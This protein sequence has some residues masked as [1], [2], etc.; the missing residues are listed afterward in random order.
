MLLRTIQHSHYL[1]LSAFTKRQYIINFVISKGKIF[2]FIAVVCSLHLAV[3]QVSFPN[4]IMAIYCETPPRIDGD[5]TDSI[6]IVAPRIS[7]FTQR[8]LRM[9][10]PATERTE[11][12]IAYDDKKIYIAVWCFDSRPKTITAKELRRDFNPALDDNF[13]ILLDT[14]RDKRNAFVFYTNPNAARGDYQVFD[15]GK[16]RNFNWNGV[17]DVR[18]SRTQEGWFAEFEIPFATLKFEN[19]DQAQEW[20]INFERNIV[21]K[22]EQ[23]RWQGWKRDNTFEQVNAAGL[24]TGLFDLKSR[25]FIEVKPYAIAGGQGTEGQPNQGILNGGGDINYLITPTYRLNVTI[26]TDFAQVES[27]AQQVNLTRFPLFFPE[28]REFFLEGE[29]YF[30][31]GFGGDRIIPFY[32]RRIGL[33]SNRMPVPMLF[34]ARLLGKQGNSTLGVMNIQTGAT[35]NAQAENFTALS[36]RQDVGTQSTVGMMSVHKITAD[37]WHTTT[38]AYGRYSTAKFLN[39]K[40]LNVGGALITTQNSDREFT[41]EAYA[42][43]F[44]VQYPNDYINVFMSTQRSPEPFE[45]EVGLMRR[46]NFEEY[47]AMASFRPRPSRDSKWS[48]I[49]QFDFSPGLFT[50]VMYNDT[51]LMQSI[52]YMIRPFALETT[53]GDRMGVWWAY[54][55]EGL[56]EDFR[57]APGVVIPKDEYF[58]TTQGFFLQTFAGRTFSLNLNGSV[59]GFFDGRANNVNGALNWRINKNLSLSGTYNSTYTDLPAGSFLTQLMGSRLNYAFNPNLFGL[60]FGQWNNATNELVVNYRLQWIPFPGSDFFFIINQ[61]FF[62]DNDSFRQT[63]LA[64]I[65]KFIWRFVI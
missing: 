36:W 32:T 22:R 53:G 6:W 28:L 14:Y 8:E 19:K 9:N 54:Q 42:Y 40:N 12:A 17:W 29:D 21:S 18:T 16:N 37:R 49:R 13:Y 65:G 26:N 55:G 50:Y 45:P 64:I 60:F 62:V 4:N 24:L 57:I 23:V 48:W 25:A 30:D 1:V 11:V 61:N 27:D 33:D 51:R 47:F 38:S 39:N 7:N 44:F 10:E 56:I 34:G 5:L 20:G 59:G 46:R 52:E 31:M 35:D 3:G 63:N 15:N 2:F 43:R 58:F 41:S